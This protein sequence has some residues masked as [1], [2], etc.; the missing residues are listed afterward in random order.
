MWFTRI[1]IRNPV[2]ATMMMAAFVVIGLFSYQRLKVDQF[3]DITFPV[4][5]V[6]TAYPG[7]SPESVE[8]D[9]T[10]K[11]EEAVNTISGIDQ[12]SS[13]S[14]DAQS[15][16]I[17]QFD[18]SVDAIQAA[19]DVRDKIALIRPD[20]R[21]GVK[22]PR[23]LRYDPAD[24]PIV[25][26]AV[27]NQ[28]GASLSTRDLTTV[29]DQIVRKRLETVRGVGSVTLVGGVKRQVQIDVDPQRLQA[30]SIGVDQVT[31]AVQ[32]ENQ[33]IPA[34]PLTSRAIE[35]DVQI[36]GRF[37][38]PD[39]FKRIIV[40]RRGGQGAGQT[41][42]PVTLDQV[43]NVVDGQEEP[44][45]TALLNGRRAL[46]LSI[47]KAQG[48]NTV[49]VAHGIRAAVAQLQPQ[50]PPGVKLDITDDSSINI[51]NSVNEVKR[52]LFEGAL[53]TV[54]IVF[55]FLGSWRST[56]IT[57]L[58]LPIALIGTFGFMYLSGFTINVIT[59]MALSLCVGLLIDDAI[60]VRENIVRHVQLGADHRTAALDGTK[61]IALAVLATTFSIV[62]VFLPVGFMGG[63]I[64]RFFHQF[65]VT[66]AAAVLISMFVSFTLDPMLSSIWP[67]PDLHDA[68]TNR[69]GYRYGRWI[70]SF[71]GFFDRQVD[72]LA[73]FYQR[74]LGWS[75]QH[76]AITLAIAAV[77]FFGAL[78][79][80]PFVGTEFVPNADFSQTQIGLSTP[81]GTSLDATSAKVQQVQA[82]LARYPEVRYTYATVN[83]GNTQGK[84]RAL[85]TVRLKDRRDRSR[86]VQTL[87]QVFRARLADVAGIAINEIGMPDG[88][89]STKAIQ[90]SLQGDNLD[91]LRRLSDTAQARMLKIPGL[92]DLDASLK[93]DKP[94]VAINVKRELASDLGVGVAD[95]GTALR[96]LLSG[97][98]IST[99]RAPDDQDYDVS[100]RLPRSQRQNVADLARLMITTNRTDAS[101][102]PVLVPLRQ[103]A[104]IVETTGPDVINRRDLQREVELSANVN[105]RSPGEVAADISKTLDAM[106]LPAGYRYRFE[107]STKSMNESFVY[108]V[109]ALALA[110]IFIYMI[111]A[112]QFASFAQPLAIMASLPLTLI[113]V[114]IA[115]LLFGS[116]LNMFSIIGF[117]MLMGLVTKNAILLIDFANQAR[118]GT[119]L[120]A[121]GKGREMARRD[122]LLEAAKVRLRPILM[123]TLAM[124]FGMLPLA[125]GLGEGGEQRGPLGQTVIGGVITSSLLTLVVVPVVYTVL[126]DWG[127]WV[128]R[129]LQRRRR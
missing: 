10:R 111:L 80:V 129:T 5:V 15:V 113:G 29:A 84:N 119:L 34:G 127:A 26:V 49:D 75:L 24:M 107:G 109:Q 106:H 30:L 118:R 82:I 48:E 89:G 8:S 54:L 66:V 61:E 116:T 98:A 56:V 121:S 104:D 124:I 41:N 73:V 100:V 21:D 11:I 63:I 87:N 25:T 1:S 12:I 95:I 91:E 22:E 85:I 76:R 68:E 79:L 72:T 47:I 2:L 112:S 65:G 50:L 58:T 38:T 60:V 28:P 36:K 110:V 115:L 94:V 123:T 90:L 59:L 6:Q 51:E 71:L 97:D 64:G 101:G 46:F 102:S 18:L 13:R 128:R 31:R 39:D 16:V 117:V 92:V 105:G 77:S 70:A 57:G 53:L 9:V 93:A 96:P 33:E 43:A 120:D 20:L 3:P 69:K 14:Y 44:D 62:A 27:S 99:W 7:A 88:A 17:V 122:A 74:L 40:A 67:D 126:E 35:Q 42:A 108:A 78:T 32:N 83:S 81:V 4:V 23:V 125:S 55:L 37:A 86:S 114:L 45:S 52:T 19:Q 103:I